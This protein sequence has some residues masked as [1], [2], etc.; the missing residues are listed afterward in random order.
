MHM[1][2]T[3]HSIIWYWPKDGNVVPVRR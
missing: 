3:P 1:P 2:L